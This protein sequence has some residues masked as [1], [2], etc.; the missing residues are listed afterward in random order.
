MRPRHLLILAFLAASTVTA[1]AQSTLKGKVVDEKN[2]PLEF[3]TVMLLNVADSALV[4]GAISDSAGHYS[5]PQIKEGRYLVAANMMG[6]EKAWAGPVTVAAGGTQTVPQLRLQEMVEQMKAVTVV[7]QKPMVEQH[8]DRMVINV[9]GSILATGGNALEVLEKSPGVAV[10]QDGN[11]SLNGKQG[12]MVMIDGKRTYLS[13]ADI[14]NML[15]NMTSDALEQVEIITNPS[16]KYDAAGNSGII[17]IKTKKGKNNGTNGSLTLG[18]GHGR[19]ERANSGLTL[20]HRQGIVNAF[21]SYN[22]GLNR[23]FQDL[24]IY[25]TAVDENGLNTFDQNNYMPNHWRGHNYKAGVDIFLNKKN[26]LGVML[27]GSF[28]IWGSNSDNQALHSIAG[29]GPE[30]MI[31]TLGDIDERY[32]NNTINLNYQRTFD[33]P[34]QELTFDLDYS[35]YKGRNDNFFDNRFRYFD[36][37]P[38]S[39][40]LLRSASPSDIDI[41]VAKLDYVLPIGKSKIEAGA[42][43][44]YVYSD[45]DARIEKQENESNWVMWDKFTND[46]LYQENINAAYANWSGAFGKTTVMAGLRAEHTW[47]QGESVKNDSTAKNEYLSLFPSLFVQRPLN[48]KNTLG[49]SYSRRVDRPSYQDLNPFYYLLDVTTYGKGNPLLQ[50]QFTHQMQLSHTFN[51]AIVTNLSYSV[52]DG[53]MTEILETEGLDAFQT[54]RN[55]GTLKNWSLNMSIP[56]PVAKWWNIQNNLSAYHNKYEGQYLEQ[57]LDIEQFTAS[58]YMMNNIKLPHNFAAEFSGFY[59][60]PQVWGIVKIQS[61]YMVNAGIKYSF[62][63]NDA[64]LKLGVNDIFRT[65]KFAGETIF[66]ENTIRLDNR[67]DNRR[68]NLTFNYRF[69]NKE[70]KPV[71]RKRGA[72]SDE[73]DRIKSS[74]S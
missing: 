60:T 41:W 5:L 27:N 45:N 39:V 73:Q 56:V 11:I 66:G 10:D 22:Y 49:F 9:E 64:S 20:N 26:T 69:G 42:K 68:V 62:W 63:D 28:G 67:W 70:V 14:A 18:G 16:A 1:F 31:T 50:P 6:Y 57:D 17:N 51:Q 36:Q 13:S 19:F 8:A 43:S 2:K 30:R 37:R 47:Y 71:G 3:A 4:K 58:L 44:S 55:L 25:R 7:G 12:V 53:P 35:R 74:G 29:S 48:E 24:S 38:D 54:K 52:T 15:R 72:S 33:K 61:Q 23:G 34:G 21:G 40:F 65:M 59:R 46:F 32:S